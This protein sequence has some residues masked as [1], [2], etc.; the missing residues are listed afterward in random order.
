MGIID[1]HCDTLLEC[2]LKKTGLR[3][4]K[5]HLS[6]EKMKEA[7]M[8][9]QCFAIFLTTGE[10]AVQDGV[11][12]G[13]YELFQEM[14]ELYRRELEANREMILPA[15]TADDVARNEKE[16]KLSAILTLEDCVLLDGKIERVDELADQGVRMATLIWN[17]ENS[18]GYP[19]SID[20]QLHAKGLKPFG[21][22]AVEKM[23]ERGIIVDISHLSEGGF[24]DVAKYSKKPFAAS[25]SCARALCDHSRNLTDDQLRVIGETG[26]VAGVNFYSRFLTEGSDFTTIDRIVEHAVY[27]ANKAGVEAVAMGSDFDG[28]DCELEMSDGTGYPR[29][30]E[31]LEKHFSDDDVEK[32]A[33][34]NFLRVFRE[35]SGAGR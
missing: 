17:Y 15:Y 3:S 19:N 33:S 23:N 12:I 8:T 22:E 1:M 25:H 32:I 9:G 26:G 20:P 30:L 21:I 10:S 31:A 35:C 2:Y 27:M 24:Y 4:G 13:P 29:L 14:Y 18:L 6:L 16:G 11:T 34:G 28:I 7:G 5:G